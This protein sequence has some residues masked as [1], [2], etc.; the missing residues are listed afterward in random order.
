MRWLLCCLLPFFAM[1]RPSVLFVNPSL[2][3]DPFFM[4]VEAVARIAASQLDVDLTIINGDANRL[5]QQQKLTE[6]LQ[7][8]KPDYAIVQ[9]YTGAGV[10]LME[11]LAQ[12]PVKI[13]TL[14]HMWQPE[15]APKV[16]RPG[17]LYPN[18][19]AELYFDNVEASQQLTL[20]LQQA[21]P[22]ADQLIGING[23]INFETDRRAE[24]VYQAMRQRGGTVHQIVNGKWDR[25]LA[26]E[27]SLQLLR[28]Y[29]ASRL[30]WTASDWMALGVLDALGPTAAGQYCIGGFDWIPEAQ[31]AIEQG[32]LQASAGGHFTMAA[33]ALVLIYDHVHGKLP[34]PLP[35]VPLLQLDILTREN[36]PAYQPLLRAG[37]WQQIDFRQFSR[38]HNPA[39]PHYNF[40]VHTAL[41][42]LKPR[43][44]TGQ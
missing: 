36:L 22:A 33:F 21:C 19:L 23:M 18:W 30:I 17:A 34:Q 15:E 2:I 38:T 25:Q 29:P 37:Q 20:A 9:P 31:K 28:R 42:Q 4:Q 8:H 5:L 26:A 11:L 12:Y 32:K 35:D 6:Y 39:L 41:K 1:A 16:G 14:E 40:S 24:G 44:E 13:V 7:K 27:Q 3:S 10:Q 43:N